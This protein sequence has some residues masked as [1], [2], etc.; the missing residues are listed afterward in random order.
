MAV[1]TKKKAY[2][3]QSKRADCRKHKPYACVTRS[4]CKLAKGRKRTFCRTRKNKKY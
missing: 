2:M 3:S 4:H 1:N